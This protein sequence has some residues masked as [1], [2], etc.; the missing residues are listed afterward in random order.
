MKNQNTL[1][2]AYK[3]V[4]DFETIKESIEIYGVSVGPEFIDVLKY[5][6]TFIGSIILGGIGYANIGNIKNII[7][8]YINKTT[9][10]KLSSDSEFLDLLRQKK[11]LDVNKD[12]QMNQERNVLMQKII[13]KITNISDSFTP[14]QKNEILSK[15]REKI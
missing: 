10:Q 6:A 1:E 14:E 3:E 5:W 4:R 9:I 2:E 15:V 11:S 13:E 12:S 8:K 7:Q